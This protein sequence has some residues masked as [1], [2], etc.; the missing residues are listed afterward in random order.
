TITK[1]ATNTSLSRFPSLKPN[2]GALP[3]LKG[4]TRPSPRYPG[5]SLQPF[6]LR[7]VFSAANV[8]CSADVHQ[9]TLSFLFLNYRNCRHQPCFFS[10]FQHCLPIDNG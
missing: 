8:A 3:L 10:G 4:I 1:V 2:H 7:A 9:P 5:L 6:D